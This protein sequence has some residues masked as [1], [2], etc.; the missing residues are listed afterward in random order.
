M[1][2]IPWLSLI[3][4]VNTP[5][6]EIHEPYENKTEKKNKTTTTTTTTLHARKRRPGTNVPKVVKY[7]SPSRSK[8]NN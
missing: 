3:M 1:V 7:K 6:T 4:V 2:D 5:E 8:P